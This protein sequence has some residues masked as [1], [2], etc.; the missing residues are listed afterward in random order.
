M[1]AAANIIQYLYGS[2]RSHA[3]HFCRNMKYDKISHAELHDILFVYSCKKE[4]FEFSH[5]CIL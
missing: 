3:V 4:Q 2:F 5:T 1:L